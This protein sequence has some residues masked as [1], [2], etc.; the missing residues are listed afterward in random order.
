MPQAEVADAQLAYGLWAGPVHALHLGD[1]EPGQERGRGGQGVEGG[2]VLAVRD[3][4]LED[5]ASQVMG[6]VHARRIHRLGGVPQPSPGCPPRHQMASA[7]G[8]PWRW[9]RWP[10]S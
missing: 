1:G 7:P 8:C 3:E 6:V 4:A 2:E 10:S 5:A 9:R